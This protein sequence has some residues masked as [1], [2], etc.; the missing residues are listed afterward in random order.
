M[1]NFLLKRD[2]PNGKLDKNEFRKVYK[3]FYYTGDPDTFCENVFRVFDQDGN[4]TI[5]KAKHQPHS[6]NLFFFN[7]LM[8]NLDFNEFLLAISITSKNTELDSKLQWIFKIYD[9]GKFL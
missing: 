2:F 3:S 4:E 1:A 5:G 7:Y 8:Y 6:V 9:I